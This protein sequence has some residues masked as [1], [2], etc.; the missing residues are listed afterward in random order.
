MPSAIATDSTTLCEYLDKVRTVVRR[1]PREEFASAYRQFGNDPGAFE[2]FIRQRYY[3]L[4]LQDQEEAS[5]LQLEASRT[6][7]VRPYRSHQKS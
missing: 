1:V 4:L 2:Q 5:L 3:L 6:R 7:S